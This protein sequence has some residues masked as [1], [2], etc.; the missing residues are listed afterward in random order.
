[1]IRDQRT[2]LRTKSSEW[3]K[4]KRNMMKRKYIMRPEKHWESQLSRHEKTQNI[5]KHSIIKPWKTFIL[6]NTK[7][8]SSKHNYFMQKQTKHCNA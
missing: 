7:K 1:M 3:K 6:C 2:P 8:L 5:V 4:A